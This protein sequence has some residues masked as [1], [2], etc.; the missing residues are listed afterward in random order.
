MVTF[1]IPAHNEARLLPAT[2]AALHAAGGSLDE[3]YE[4]IVVDDASS[5]ATADVARAGGA[6]V[7]SVSHR[8]IA[9]TRNAGARAARGDVL[10][11]VDADTI[12]PAATVRAALT[13]LRAG[14]EGGGAH[15]RFD[16]AIPV[17]AQV[18]LVVIMW[19]FRTARL[20]G[21]CF[22]FCT[23]AAF[24]AAGGFDERL[25]VAEEI[26]FSRALQRALPERAHP[27]RAGRFVVLR[28]TVVTSGRKLRG[29][30]APIAL[31]TLFTLFLRGP[32]VVRSRK[33]LGAWYGDRAED[34]DEGG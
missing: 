11:F 20:A 3:A 1:V 27:D 22:M 34:R 8:Q 18:L 26:A 31:W 13:A 25:F 15:V 14:A 23:R 4:I 24:D 33:H 7:V 5:D 30:N 10:V 28:E 32:G 12:V 6:R 21:G 9:A 16:G 29:P 17:Y 2:L 19:L